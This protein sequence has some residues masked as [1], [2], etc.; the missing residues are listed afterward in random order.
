M[1]FLK[2]KIENFI[3]DT[4]FIIIFREFFRRQSTA[5]VF[6]LTFFCNNSARCKRI[7]RRERVAVILQVRA[8]VPACLRTTRAPF[9]SFTAIPG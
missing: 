1:S 5:A 4:I 2:W 7:Q 3:V 8:R 9:R 6:L